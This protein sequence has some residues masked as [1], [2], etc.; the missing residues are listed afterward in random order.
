MECLGRNTKMKHYYVF[1]SPPWDTYLY[2]VIR[3][4]EGG[5]SQGGLQLC[6]SLLETT[7]HRERRGRGRGRTLLVWEREMTLSGRDQ[8]LENNLLR[9]RGVLP[10]FRW[11]Q[12]GCSWWTPNGVDWGLYR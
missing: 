7:K 8:L 2:E 6:P 12:W 1:L 11:E 10:S 4:Q 9:T 3:M 5:Q